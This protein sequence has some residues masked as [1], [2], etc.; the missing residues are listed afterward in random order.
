MHYITKVSK[1][2]GSMTG[3]LRVRVTKFSKCKGERKNLIIKQASVEKSYKT[4]VHCC[5]EYDFGC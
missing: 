4:G 2:Q 1:Q 3:S 5:N